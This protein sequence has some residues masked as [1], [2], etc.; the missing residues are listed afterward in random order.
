[1]FGFAKSTFNFRWTG[2]NLD[3]I[4]QGTG[5]ESYSKLIE[6]LHISPAHMCRYGKIFVQ[7]PKKQKETQTCKT[8]K[9]KKSFILLIKTWTKFGPEW[10]LELTVKTQ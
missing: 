10:I 7:Q 6:T 9:D 4:I 5:A 2:C 3:D 8:Q 1:M